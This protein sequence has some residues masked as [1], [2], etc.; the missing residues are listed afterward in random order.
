[1]NGDVCEKKLSIG[2]MGGLVLGS[3]GFSP[4]TTNEEA[5]GSSSDSISGSGL[6]CDPLVSIELGPSSASS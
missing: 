5:S 1:M 2:N 6:S 4:S 3:N